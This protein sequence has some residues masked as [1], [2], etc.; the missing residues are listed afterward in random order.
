MPVSCW[1]AASDEDMTNM[2]RFWRD[3]RFFQ[4]WGREVRE[5]REG[6]EIQ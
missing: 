6:A 3:T 2:G 1:K 4:L 5:V